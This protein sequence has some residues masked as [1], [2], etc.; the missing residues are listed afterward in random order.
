MDKPLNNAIPLT[1]MYKSLVKHYAQQ[2]KYIDK[3]EAENSELK[4]QLIESAV[5]MRVMENKF[6]DS[7]VGV[8]KREIAEFEKKRKNMIQMFEGFIRKHKAKDVE[9]SE[10]QDIFDKFE[11]NVFGSVEQP[12]DSSVI[13]KIKNIFKK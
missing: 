2:N 9:L 5:K 8:M 1:A 6:N 13:D 12:D 10:I 11:R 4:K 7:D 3:L